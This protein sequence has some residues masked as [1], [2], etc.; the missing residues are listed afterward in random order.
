MARRVG[1]AWL[2]RLKAQA[3]ALMLAALASFAGAPAFAVGDCDDPAYLANFATE[4]SGLV[5]TTI[6]CVVAFDIGYAAPEGPRRIRAIH[7]AAA[8]WLVSDPSLSA[9]QEGVRN[10]IDAF[11]RLGDYAI[12]DVTILIV[13]DTALPLSDPA[14]ADDGMLAGTDAYRTRS[15][16]RRGECY[17]TLFALQAV[18]MDP[19]NI[20]Y[21]IAHELFHCIEGATLSD[22][23]MQTAGGG[24]AW[25]AEG[26]A[27]LFAAVAIPGIGDVAGRAAGFAR[28]V[29]DEVPLY[30]LAYTMAV[31]FYW[32]ESDQGLA[33]LLPFL[34]QMAASDGDAAQRAAMRD[35]MPESDWLRFAQAYV[36]RDIRHPQGG[37][38]SYATGEGD[39]YVFEE[40]RTERVTLEP[41]VLTQASA[42]YG[43]GL[44]ANMQAPEE[45]A[46]SAR[47]AEGRDWRAY[48]AEVDAREGRGGRYRI[49]A[50]NT[51]DGR[52][53]VRIEAERRA[54]CAPC[55]GSDR[56]DVCLAG[57]WVQSGGGAVEWMRAQG[58]PITR[59][60]VSEQIITYLGDGSYLT[61]PFSV[62]LEERL[63]TRRG[64]VIGEGVGTAAAA[65]GRWSAE[66]GRLNVCQESGGV[67]GRVTVTS[68]G[69]TGS[70][71]I[72]VPGGGALT[73]RY[74]CSESSLETSL[75]FGGLPPM[76][77]QFSRISVEPPEEDLPDAPEPGGAGAEPGAGSG[78]GGGC[79]AED[80]DPAVEDECDRL[81]R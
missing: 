61:Q 43:C 78:G 30:D 35:A 39:E 59:A 71:P 58:M 77:T 31:F 19:D 40:N 51:G 25:W 4:E 57:T 44:W 67:R 63:R 48:P 81:R 62:E 47:E 46:I 15:G 11:S 56:V 50:L 28:A 23:Q 36:D 52:Q 7:D 24:G 41:F 74:S 2:G 80:P 8:G 73:M 13:E 5:T 1:A 22:A 33:R 14:S 32:Y 64:T 49:A 54:S 27:E 65:G 68:P 70:M 3:Q 29:E 20:G 37:G 17:V 38:L 72:N 9:L 79:P 76:V 6:T 12:D 42:Q 21:V 60:Q 18:G 34:R 16:D 69:G 45:Q 10:S 53:V 66:E 26:A 55:A 75:D